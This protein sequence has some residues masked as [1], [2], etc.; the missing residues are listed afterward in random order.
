MKP[1]TLRDVAAR[2]KVSITTVSKALADQPDISQKTKEYIRKLCEEMNYVPNT[3][4]TSLRT[5]KTNLIGFVVCDNTNPYYDELL[6]VV[7]KELLD[8]G[9]MLII[10]NASYDKDREMSYINRLIGM[11]VEGVLITPTSVE[12]VDTLKKYGIPHVLVG[13]CISQERDNYVIPDDEQACYLA[14]KC[15]LKRN[16]DIIPY[17]LGPKGTVSN[18]NV[19]IKGYNKALREYGY[20]ENENYI[21]SSVYNNADGYRTAK[22]IIAC[23]KPPYSFVCESDYIAVGVMRALQEA[24]IKI[25]DEA[26]IVGID[27]LE[28]FTYIHPLLTS[29]DTELSKMGSNSVKMLIDLIEKKAKKEKPEERHIVIPARLVDKESC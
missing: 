26:G 9:Y 29:V 18:F 8:S 6:R 14:A 16:K 28:L 23:T 13:R 24:G 10:C 7:E 2:A 12:G 15:C 11:N 5:Q 17:F 19:K 20:D 21:K 3:N 4:A 27:N 1:T 22:E 25:P